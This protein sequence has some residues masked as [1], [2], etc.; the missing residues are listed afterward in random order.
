[1]LDDMRSH[2]D[3]MGL[4]PDQETCRVRTA[5]IL[6]WTAMRE[7][8]PLA[9]HATD[10]CFAFDHEISMVQAWR[11]GCPQLFW[12]GYSLAS[13][14]AH[15][16]FMD[17]NTDMDMTRWD[18]LREYA[19][20]DVVLG[21]GAPGGALGGA[22]AATLVRQY[23]YRES[24]LYLSLKIGCEP[25]VGAVSF[26]LC[27]GGKETIA[28][29]L[30]TR[31][32]VPYSLASR[33]ASSW[34]SGRWGRAFT[35][36]ATP[37]DEHGMNLN[38]QWRNVPAC[39]Y[40]ALEGQYIP[41]SGMSLPGM[42]DTEGEAFLESCR[43]CALDDMRNGVLRNYISPDWSCEEGSILALAR[44][45]K[46][47]YPTLNVLPLV[48]NFIRW[49]GV[50]EFLEGPLPSEGVLLARVQTFFVDLSQAV[51]L[52]VLWKDI[53]LPYLFRVNPL[54]GAAPTVSAAPAVTV[55]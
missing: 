49:K 36:H 14:G 34:A 47:R 10:P 9:P 5:C 1:M 8:V 20:I 12:I 29:N 21:G 2:C 7:G 16:D 24:S 48:D 25:S 18:I 31:G 43:W 28:I 26:H 42:F 19:W 51:L 41:I 52:P 27:D 35:T 17:L 3:S 37:E 32:W 53:I 39:G 6:Q 44:S 46:T 30:S 22:P 23:L 38:A 55:E 50:D 4:Y 11:H 40:L 13:D 15:A 54:W 33:V 45:V